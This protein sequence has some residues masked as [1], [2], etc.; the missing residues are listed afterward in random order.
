[1]RQDYEAA[2]KLWNKVPC[3]SNGKVEETLEYFQ[4]VENYR[5]RDY[6]PWLKKILDRGEYKDK[7]VLEVGYGQGTDLVQF[8]KNHAS[9]FGVDITE[10][11][12]SLAKKNFALRGL[13]ASLTRA[14]VLHLPFKDESFDVVYSNG[15]LHHIKAI[16]S[17]ISEIYRVLKR[18]GGLVLI[19]YNRHSAFYLIFTLFIR[20]LLL[21][22]YFRLGHAGL[23][24]TIETGADG[25]EI[26]PFVKLYTKKSVRCLLN[27]FSDLRITVTHLEKDHF[28]AVGKI[29]PNSVI[30][31][32][33]PYLG[34]YI[35]A[36]AKK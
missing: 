15:V 19:L 24:S 29:L 34:W 31:F 14:N 35:V 17:S 2:R 22:N 33:S 13:K 8:A 7:R 30:N 36:V 10:R 6:A 12:C 26:K 16:D 25:R 21:G 20:G 32:F 5:Y 23:L 11:H 4:A 27:N 28:S 9:C 1:M 18:G 3:G